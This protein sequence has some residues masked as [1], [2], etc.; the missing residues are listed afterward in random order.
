MSIHIHPSNLPGTN[1]T[2][3]GK[4][5]FYFQQ[6]IFFIIKW[7]RTSI[8]FLLNFDHFH[9]HFFISY[10]PYYHNNPN[11]LNNNRNQNNQKNIINKK[12]TTV[13]SITTITIKTIESIKTMM[14]M[15]SILTLIAIKP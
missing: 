12:I 11:K 5:V 14:I 1:L 9:K 7:L 3:S 8:N 2:T 4:T 15:I 6:F 13:T 10:Y